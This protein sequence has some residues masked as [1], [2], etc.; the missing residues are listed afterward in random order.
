MRD[1][2]ICV[3][4]FREVWSELC[5]QNVDFEINN[6]KYLFEYESNVLYKDFFRKTFSFTSHVRSIL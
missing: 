2:L 4:I 3:G 1:D 6:Y 5:H